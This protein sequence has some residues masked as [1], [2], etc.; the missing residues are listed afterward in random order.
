MSKQTEIAW[1]AGF[2]DG[3]GCTT[4]RKLKNNR[5]GIALTVTQKHPELLY[6][7]QK[8]VGQGEVYGPYANGVCQFVVQTEESVHN[9]LDA[10]WPYLGERKRRQANRAIERFNQNPEIAPKKIR[11]KHGHD[12]RK[13]ENLTWGG[14]CRL[15]HNRRSLKHHHAKKHTITRNP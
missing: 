14:K 3:E 11:C 13:P 4:I 2:F 6:R 15:C 1:A 7:F 5:V 10:L 9:V 12:L 8:A